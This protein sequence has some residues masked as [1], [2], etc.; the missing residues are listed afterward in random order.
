L[1]AESL[2]DVVNLD[3]NKFVKAM[4]TSLKEQ[5]DPDVLKLQFKRFFSNGGP[6][7][8]EFVTSVKS[9]IFTNEHAMQNRS[10]NQSKKLQRSSSR[11]LM[12]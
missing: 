5:V 1:A 4:H 3:T 11:C 2:H 9:V 12:A 7:T 10:K 6:M 8:G